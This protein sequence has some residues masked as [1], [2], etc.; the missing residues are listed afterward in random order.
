MGNRL[1]IP[2]TGL[3]VAGRL[4]PSNSNEWKAPQ[5]HWTISVM[6]HFRLWLLLAP[7]VGVTALRGK[8]EVTGQKERILLEIQMVESVLIKGHKLTDAAD[9][10]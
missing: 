9:V 3:G 6:T 4:G 5:P 1:R 7:T 2:D 10:L 8:K